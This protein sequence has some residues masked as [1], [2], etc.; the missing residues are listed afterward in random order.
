MAGLVAAAVFAASLDSS[1]TAL[2]FVVPGTVGVESS[3]VGRRGMGSG[4]SYRRRAT[5]VS[6]ACTRL[7]AQL[8]EENILEDYKRRLKE[9]EQMDSLPRARRQEKGLLGKVAAS[10]KKFKS[11]ETDYDCNE[12]GKN[13]PLRC[14]DVILT[15]VCVD[16]DDRGGGLGV[17]N[18]NPEAATVPIPV[19]VDDGYTTQP[20]QPGWPVSR[21]F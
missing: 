4:G 18:W 12:D 21:D 14:V 9:V 17:R 7:K 10:I 2:A 16:Q 3:V 20:G 5:C 13:W 8:G 6:R 19:R 15:K 1:N 11:C